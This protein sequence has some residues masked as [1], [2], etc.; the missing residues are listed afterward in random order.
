M[1]GGIKPIRIGGGKV[2]NRGGESR[3]IIQGI[4]HLGKQAVVKG[5]RVSLYTGKKKGIINF[6]YIYYYGE[7]RDDDPRD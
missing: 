5:L 4:D 7:R 3:V 6:N 2:L 1:G